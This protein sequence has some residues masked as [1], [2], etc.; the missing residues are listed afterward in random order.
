MKEDQSELVNKEIFRTDIKRYF[1]NY[2]NEDKLCQ[3]IPSYTYLVKE[4][5]KL[6]D[7]C[8][9][10]QFLHIYQKK[11]LLKSMNAKKLCRNGIP[12]KYIKSVLL[13]MFHVDFSSEYYQIKRRFVLKNREIVSLGSYVPSF[14]TNKSFDESLPIHFLNDNGIEALKEILWLL[15]SVVSTIEYSPLIIKLASLLLIFLTKEDTYELM[16]TLLEINLSPVEINKIRWHFRYTYNENLQISLSMHESLFHLSDEATLKKLAIFKQINCSSEVIL[17]DLSGSFFLDYFNF[18]GVIGFLPFF[19]Y[20][21]TKAIY[22]INYALFK[23][24]DLSSLKILKEPKDKTIIDEI[25]LKA[26]E[27][28]DINKINQDSCMFKLNR[29][30]NN[31]N[32]QVAYEDIISNKRHYYFLPSFTPHSEILSESDIISL[33]A[34]LP[35]EVKAFNGKILYNSVNAPD[36]DLTS[37]YEMCSKYDRFSVILLI[38]KTDTDEVFGTILNHNLILSEEGNWATPMNA[39]LFS[40]K[41]YAKVYSYQEDENEILLCEPGAIR[42]GNGAEGP[43]ISISHDLQSGLTERDSIFGTISF[44]ISNDGA[45]NIKAM[46][47]YLMI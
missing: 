47:V 41:P 13:K 28:K 17:H 29:K 38:I 35:F 6:D 19:L 8:G 4:L 43:A 1:T 26:F 45:F 20:E 3:R 33:W 34:L 23:N 22:R 37:L 12:V 32:Q 44:T 27:L 2:F 40:I 15:N 14:T 36:I 24:I 42:F 11:T 9:E 16:R 30:N 7:A 21:G 46:E 18:V 31:F 5:K 39:Y 25:K 10:K